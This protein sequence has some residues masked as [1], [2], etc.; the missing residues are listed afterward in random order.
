MNLSLNPISPLSPFRKPSEN[1][2]AVGRAYELLRQDVIE[3]LRFVQKTI[4]YRYC[5]FHGLFHDEMAVVSRR[6][7]GAWPGAGIRLI[8]S[9]TAPGPGP[10]TFR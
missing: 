2:I 1:A 5:R 6:P 9:M 4:G 7:D 3:H 10:E 8:K